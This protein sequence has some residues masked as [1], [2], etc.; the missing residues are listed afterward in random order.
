LSP[1][2]KWVFATL[3]TTSQ[4]VLLPT[5]P[6][7]MRQVPRGGIEIYGLGGSWLPDGK[8]L[9]FTGREQGHKMRTYVQEIDGGSPRAITP[10]GVTG[11]VISPD[12]K[13]VIAKD[14]AQKP[15]IYPVGGGEPRPIADLQSDETAP[16]W[17]AD[18]RS[19][20]VYRPEGTP[21]KIYRLDAWTGHRELWKELVPADPSGILG[22][23][24]FQTTPDGKSYV[25]VLSKTLSTLYLAQKIK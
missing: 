2:G 11:T 4:I 25:Y 13:F 24:G 12:G 5:G 20:Y 10:E 21:I 19:L 15:L 8:A 18:N 9:I 16:R 14:E 6:G 7:E 22:P 3:L 23:A 1:D 17:A